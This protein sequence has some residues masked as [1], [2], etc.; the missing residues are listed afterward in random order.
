MWSGA[1]HVLPFKGG[2]GESEGLAFTNFLSVIYLKT[3]LNRVGCLLQ[4]NEAFQG[5]LLIY[6]LLIFL[7]FIKC[8]LLVHINAGHSK[9]IFFKFQFCNFQ[10]K[11]GLLRTSSVMK[12][13]FSESANGADQRQEDEW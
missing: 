12:L 2:G 3:K 5:L 10:F 7:K 1:Q 8:N 4:F 6:K 13:L 11:I 9:N